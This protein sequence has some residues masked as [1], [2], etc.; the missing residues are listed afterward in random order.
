MRPGPPR[1]LLHDLGDVGRGSV[2]RVALALHPPRRARE[3]EEPHRG[4]VALAVAAHRLGRLEGILGRLPVVVGGADLARQCVVGHAVGRRQDADLEHLPAAVGVLAARMHRVA[5]LKVV[6]LARLEG[7]VVGHPALD[8][9]GGLARQPRELVPVGEGLLVEDAPL[10]LGRVVCGEVDRGQL[11]AAALEQEAVARRDGRHEPAAQPHRVRAV[12]PPGAGEEDAHRLGEHVRAGQR[13]GG[14]V[15]PLPHVVRARLVLGAAELLDPRDLVPVAVADVGVAR[16]GAVVVPPVPVAPQP[17][18]RRQVVELLEV[19]VPR[20][21]GGVGVGRGHVEERARRVARGH[22]PRDDR[23]RAARLVAVSAERV[24][25]DAQHVAALPLEEGPAVNRGL[26]HAGE[27]FGEGEAA[28]EGVGVDGRA[29]KARRER[30]VRAVAVEL[31]AERPAAAR[32]VHVAED[33]DGRRRG[34][35]LDAVEARGG[36]GVGGEHGAARDRPDRRLEVRAHPER[37]VAHQHPLR[38]LRLHQRAV[39][40][41]DGHAR[42]GAARAVDAVGVDD[43]QIGGVSGVRAHAAHDGDRLERARALIRPDPAHPHRRR[44]QQRPALFGGDGEGDIVLP[45]RQA[46]WQPALEDPVLAVPPVGAV[47]PRQRAASALAR[48]RR[49]VGLVHG[50]ALLGGAGVACEG[51]TRSAHRQGGAP[52][53]ERGA[54]VASAR[55]ASG[56]PC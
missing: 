42:V 52:V 41:A 47:A 54:A 51:G 24:G 37:A 46:L 13:E 45:E 10:A 50:G 29:A 7:A 15:E 6:A 48:P 17:E 30:R 18:G 31:A 49:Q 27:A 56:R 32:G 8:A 23:R 5:H 9:L 14:R 3:V 34:A 44:R 2:C 26:R 55:I 4:R 33:L 43:E 12:A 21:E 16:V 22:R 38:A 25:A 35:R 40:L 39:D 20:R 1:R 28:G 53:N 36:R 19:G 11:R